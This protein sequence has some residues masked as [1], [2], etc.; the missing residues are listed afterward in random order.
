M[1]NNCFINFFDIYG[2]EFKINVFGK[3]KVKTLWG[4][5]IGVLTICAIS[6]YFTYQI[7]NVLNK[8]STS[9]IYNESSSRIAVN[10]FTDIPIMFKVIDASGMKI[11]PEGIYS[12][13]PIYLNYIVEK[14]EKN[15]S[16]SYTKRIPIEIEPCQREKHLGEYIDLFENIDVENYQCIPREKYN[17]TLLSSFGDLVNGFSEIVIY[18]TKCSNSTQKCLDESILM[19]KLTEVFF[20]F[21]HVGYQIDNFNYTHPIQKRVFTITQSFTYHI[22]KRWYLS[23]MPMT[24]DTDYGFILDNL[25]GENYFTLNSIS[26]DINPVAAGIINPNPQLATF[27]I[28]NTESS[29]NYFRGYIKLS[30]IVAST[31]GAIKIIMTVCHLLNYMITHA[32]VYKKVSNLMFSFEELA[33]NKSTSNLNFTSKFITPIPR[34]N[35]KIGRI[36]K[37]R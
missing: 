20:V 26:L 35:S 17:L 10:N 31:G 33:H 36:F 11:A 16:K 9:I 12:I 25:I 15:N 37:Q 14:G 18:L 19:K 29:G 28:R 3:E 24:Y 27:H 8:N 34:E 5:L 13:E 22:I 30:S 2:T 21:A 1:K 7:Y 4:S 6:A 32:L 23:F